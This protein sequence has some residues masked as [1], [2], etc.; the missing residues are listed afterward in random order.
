MAQHGHE[1]ALAFNLMRPQPGCSR[2]PAETRRKRSGSACRNK[3]KLRMTVQKLSDRSFIFFSG[4]GTGRV[5]QRSS[6]LQGCC[7]R[8]QN[9]TLHGGIFQRRFRPPLLDHIFILAE[10]AFAGAWRIDQYTVKKSGKGR[11]NPLRAF[12]QHDSVADTVQL[13]I[14]GQSLGPL[15]MKIVA[16]QQPLTLQ[17]GGNL[18]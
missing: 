6:R 13:Q 1:M 11:S 17:L 14:L 18:C 10:H 2:Q 5:D 3:R 16:D 8:S 4:K 12:I 9:F 15:R 7:S